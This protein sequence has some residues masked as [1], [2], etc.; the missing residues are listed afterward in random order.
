[1]WGWWSGETSH[2]RMR[3][4]NNH[5]S[6]FRVKTPHVF[7]IVV[8]VFFI[9]SLYSERNYALSA[10]EDPKN[11]FN[12]HCPDSWKVFCVD[13]QNKLTD[14]AKFWHLNYNDSDFLFLRLCSH[15]NSLLCI[16]DIYSKYGDKYTYHAT[17]MLSP[18]AQV[19]DDNT[20][21]CDVCTSGL[22]VWFFYKNESRF[23]FLS[24]N[25][26]LM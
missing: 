7:A 21:P 1:M 26:I 22:R 9:F 18:V 20:A 10:A 4:M 16:T 2:E 19:S 25:K 17:A 6:N 11:Q 5:I 3:T 24:K 23:I 14:F 15:E 13:R 12:S 8:M